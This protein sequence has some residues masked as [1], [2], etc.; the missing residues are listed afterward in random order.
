LAA[1]CPLGALHKP[2]KRKPLPLT[3]PPLFK[4]KCLTN[5]WQGKSLTAKL[6][7]QGKTG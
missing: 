7:L 3:A 5:K 2:L 4:K 1:Q 6:V